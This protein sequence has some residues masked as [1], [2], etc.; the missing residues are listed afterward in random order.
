MITNFVLVINY[1]TPNV[2]P[3]TQK[4]A[5]HGIQRSQLQRQQTEEMRRKG[6]GLR[7]PSTANI[8]E[9]ADPRAASKKHRKDIKEANAQRRLVR[10]ARKREERLKGK[11]EKQVEV[12]TSTR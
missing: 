7:S 6:L 2:F 1:I 12:S 4:M 3:L 8:I 5:R 10:N 11:V 9:Q